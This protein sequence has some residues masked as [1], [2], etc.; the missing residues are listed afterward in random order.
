MR[1]AGRAGR[2]RLLPWIALMTIVLT[3]A[4][5]AETNVGAAPASLL[6]AAKSWGYQLQKIRPAS[7]A[8]IPYD[9]FVIDYSSDGTDAQAFSKADIASLK[10]KPDGARRIVLAYL[11][12]G[13]AETYRYYWQP[14]WETSPPAWAGET[15][16]RYRSNIVVRY[17]DEDWQSIIFRGDNN[18]LDR[19]LAAGFD[20][21]Y[22]DRVDVHQELEQEHPNAGEEMISFV[23]ELAAHARSKQPGFLVVP[24][25]AEELLVRADYREVIDGI[26]KEDL[27]FGDSRSKHPNAQNVIDTGVRYLKEMT[28]DGKPVFV[29]EY[30]D[31]PE[32]ITAARK[33]IEGYGFIPHFAKRSLDVMRIGDFLPARQTRP[34]RK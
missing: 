16:K 9:V 24:Q 15:N 20:G 31:K 2:H 22:L 11:S 26:A 19:I 17:W 18:Y 1:N 30:V 34:A 33:E 32:Q 5:S 6:A 3:S 25:N 8:G 23:K 10:R 29:V 7:I 28:Q 14:Q 4:A 27:L 13:E 21:I 12:I